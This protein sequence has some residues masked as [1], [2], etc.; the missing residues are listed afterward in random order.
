[1]AEVREGGGSGGG[2]MEEGGR[3][4]REED[5]EILFEGLGRGLFR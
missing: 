3:D 2:V 1:M 5:C 4:G